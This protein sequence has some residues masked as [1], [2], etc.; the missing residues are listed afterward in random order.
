[1]R[2]ERGS[3]YPLNGCGGSRPTGKP[4]RDAHLLAGLETLELDTADLREAQRFAHALERAVGLWLH[5]RRRR[6]EGPF[7]PRKEMAR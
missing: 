6:Q 1:M 7:T 2:S 3:P 4:P 5:M